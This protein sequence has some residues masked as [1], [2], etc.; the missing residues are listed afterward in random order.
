M[1]ENTKPE[2]KELEQKTVAY[3][4]F[5]GNY[6]GN[7]KVFKDLFDKLCGWA[8]P[9]NLISSDTVFSSAYYDDHNS[10]PPDELKLD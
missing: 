10:T 1:D 9:K 6:M 4:S 7:T 5:I 3:V 8:G 2:I